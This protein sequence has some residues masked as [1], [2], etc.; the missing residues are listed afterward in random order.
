[1]TFSKNFNVYFTFFENSLFS[2]KL[3]TITALLSVMELLARFSTF[4]TVFLM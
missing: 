4:R 3:R 1:M 2:T